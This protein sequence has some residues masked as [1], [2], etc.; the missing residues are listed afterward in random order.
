MANLRVVET[1][2]V[3]STTVKMS[4]T[5]DLDQFISAQNIIIV[6]NVV[7]TPSPDVLTVKIKN[8][9]LTI[10]TRP[11]TP[12]STY[13]LTLQSTPQVKFKSKNGQSFLLEDGSTNVIL[14][15]GAEDPEDKVRDN[16]LDFLKDN[17]Y[18]LDSNT[19]VRTIINS[20]SNSLTTALHDVGQAKNDNYLKLETFDEQKT[21]GKGPYDRLNEEGTYRIVRVGKTPSNQPLSTS[22]NFTSFPS[23]PVSLQKSSVFNEKLTVGNG[24]DVS[25]RLVLTVSKNPVVK[26]T[27][28][29]FVYQSGST[30]EYNINTLGYQIYNSRYDTDHASTFLT[31][32]DDQFKLN[33]SLLD[34]DFVFPAQGDYVL[35]SYDY[36]S[37]GIYVNE[38][39]ISILQTLSSTR[40]VVLPLLV[41]FNLAHAPVVDSAGNSLTI[42]GIEFLDPNSNPPFAYTHPA[43]TTQI[44][45]RFEALPFRPGQYSVDYNS[46][47]VYVYGAV[48]NDGTGNYPPVVTYNYKNFFNSRLDFTY[49]PETL[50][51]VAN[52]LR[53]LI[54]QSAS[55][56][57]NFENTLI[58]GVDYEAQIHKE[59]INERIENKLISTNSFYTKNVPI[60]NVFRIYN[61]TTGEVYNATRWNN[62]IVYF[63]SNIPP[64]ILGENRER[65]S[66]VQVLNET[67]II[68]SEFTNALST[69]V[70]KIYLENNTIM[71]STEDVI[72]SSYNTSCLFSRSDVFTNELFFDSQVLTETQNIDKLTVGKYQIDYRNGVVYLGVSVG[73]NND[74]GSI[75]YRKSVITPVNPHI[76]SVSKI[77]YSLNQLSGVNKYLDYTSFD[78]GQILPSSFDLSD[79]R[80]LN[81]DTTL[82]YIVSSG[83][84]TITDNIQNLRHLF[85]HYDLENN[86]VPTNFASA[87]TVLNN[88]ITLNSVG[89]QKQE[90]HAVQTGLLINV[91]FISP[92]IEIGS[93]VSIVRNNDGVMFS[94]TFVG[95]VIT[96]NGTGSPAVNDI[97]TV[98]YNVILNGA[99]TPIVDYN[100][101]DYYIDY[102]YLADEILVSYEY[103]DNVIDFRESSALNEGDTYYVSYIS[104][105][106]RDALLKNFGSLI[107]ISVIQ[108]FDTTLP[109]ENY[110]DALIGAL[111][112]FTK[113]PTLPAMKSIVSNITKIDPEIIESVFNTWSL[114][115]SR[116]YESKIKTTNDIMLLPGKFDQGLLI[117]KPNQTVTFPVSSH[118]RLEQGTLEAWIIPEWDGIDNDATLTFENIQKD[119]Y[120]ISASNIYIGASSFHPMFNSNGNFSLNRTDKLSPIGLPSSIHTVLSGMFIYY[121]DI[122]KKWN[123]LVKD[124]V[125][126]GYDGYSYTGSIQ[127]SG[128]VYNVMF[129]PGL[130]EI[131]DYLRSTVNNI[132]FKFNINVLDKNN[133]DGYDSAHD[134]YTPGYSFDGIVFQADDEHYLFDFGKDTAKNRFSLFKDGKGYLNFQVFDRGNNK[135]KKNQ[136]KI[137]ADISNWLAGQKHHVAVSWILNSKN[138]QDEMHLFIDGLEVSNI[139]RYGGRPVATSTDRFRSI[140]PEIVAG[141][142]PLNTITNVDMTTTAGSNIVISNSVNFTSAGIVPGNTIQ[143]LETGFGTYTITIVS[144][145]I[146]TLSSSMPASLDNDA[147]FSVNPYSVVVSSEIDLYSNI[148]VSILHSGTEVEIPGLRA[149]IPGYTISKNI[150]NQ[151][152]LTLLGNAV[153][154]DSI[155]IRTLG[156]NHRRARDKV[157]IWGNTQSVLKTRLPPP[158]NLDEVKINSI[159]LP[160]TTI[161][162]SNATYAFGVFTKTIFPSQ[163]SN[164]TEGRT[165]SSRIT[166]DNVDFSTPATMTING[167]TAAGP[168]FEVLSFTSEGIKTTVNKWK[169]IVSIV[170]VIKPVNS[171]KNSA[172]IDLKETYSI[173]NPEGNTNYPIIRYSYKV[174]HNTT[175]SG[176]GTN[177]ITDSGG[178]FA[179]SYVDDVLVISSPPSVAGTYTITNRIDNYNVNVTPIPPAAFTNG[180]YDIYNVSIGRSGFQNGFFFLQASGTS[181]TPYLL[182][183]GFYEFDY[184][185]YLEIPFDA[186][187]NLNAY[188]GS[189]FTGKKQAN[190]I[191]DEFR[192]LSTKLTDVRVGETLASNA[193]SITTNSTAIR[194]FKPN[195]T[196]LLLLHFDSLP[197]VNSADY[198]VFSDSTFR[199]SALSVNENFNQSLYITDKPLIVDNK[200][201]LTT[202]S[203]GSIEFW[204]SPR[205]DTYNDPNFRYYFDASGSVI[206]NIS[207][208]TNGTVKVDG[209]ISRVLS[210]RLAS[211]V[212]NTGV[213]YFVGGKVLEDG[214]TIQLNSALPFQQTPVKVD[215]VPSGL[216]GN[217]ISIYK[218]REGFITFNVKASG[219]DFQ[220]RQ[221]V[222]WTRDTWHR[223]R[224]TYKFNRIDHKDEI[225]LFIDGEERGLIMFGTGLFFGPSLIFGQGFSAVTNQILV[226]DI[227]FTDPINQFFIGSDYFGVNGAQARID[228]LRLSNISRSPITVAGQPLDVNYNSNLNLIY[229][230]APDAFTT[231]L[232]NFDSLLYKT[233]D[234]AL[235]KNSHSGLFDFTMNILDS[236]DI[237]K[238]SAKIK[239]ILEALI[240]ALKPAQSRVELN[241][242]D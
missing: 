167:T 78:D 227:N 109:R 44:P 181:N 76:I 166:G 100:R 162:P 175:L 91:N 144:G 198:W 234:F 122:A 235:L 27:K 6:A 24:I 119:G 126:D 218:D 130:G 217:R 158:I 59:I 48:E 160:L 182:K 117:N 89:I 238:D 211:D 159:L 183:Q 9:I 101:G 205:F 16:I 67:L 47:T 45:F 51:L 209:R 157:Y 145:N 199:Q 60:T 221:P 141:T 237:V 184:S 127:S 206:E 41:T 207:S 99:A 223:I 107:D 18:N 155:L 118:L 28:I 138:R 75:S 112:S 58:P 222:F 128:E 2:V 134:G 102:T 93:V 201:L 97:V 132:K 84:I 113:G 82:P 191:L 62:N 129:I 135:G 231:Y 72:G 121:D 189:D 226:S 105:A 136:Y 146:L 213:N 177:V 228:N 66:F 57:F 111:Q 14:I 95:N 202:S 142:V 220:V 69:R 53:N 229:P 152:V 19:L 150:F 90:I 124:K 203:E 232:L 68:D 61:E 156:L 239:Q 71:S 21:R 163:P 236:F 171:L 34:S 30:F 153:V 137:S 106:L 204:V 108:S 5:D 4:F 42:G 125:S 49:N 55:I 11:M 77:Y 37:L 35:I 31:L 88:I 7:G 23:D 87:T 140:K 94:G 200:G 148:A 188:I 120:A 240:Y 187:S 33:D 208:I 50:E 3:D 43:F 56:S 73:Q 8:N 116:L 39:S 104:G 196:T 149:A 36:K 185:A 85:D 186:V 219:I 139:L 242:V 114:G 210:V 169:T 15:T 79:E 25:N 197:L 64:A 170:I 20:I 161:G 38:N 173:T 83:T 123:L 1:R 230:V 176:S 12:W 80:F 172:A 98:I 233:T 133:A 54:G 190:A 212:N 86:A 26:L 214:R 29:V 10:K 215:Y 46:G 81:G 224:A 174:Q 195:N 180:V 40:E 192:I 225:R 65:A 154:G 74:V 96:L 216:A 115:I 32:E 103:G 110:R 179:A 92:G 143:I 17:V 70:F 147:R 193:D 131:D 168:T 178:F 63:S 13:F 151:N 164:A 22:F 165:L 52:P 194:E 241:Y